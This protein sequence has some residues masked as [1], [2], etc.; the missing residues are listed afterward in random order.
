MKS[1]KISSKLILSYAIVLIFMVVLGVSS[2]VGISTLNEVI[3]QYKDNTVPT[4]NLVWQA[5]RDLISSQRNLLIAV[6]ATD[7]DLVQHYLNLAAKDRDNVFVSLD[8]LKEYE[9]VDDGKVDKAVSLIHQGAQY[10]EQI[11]SF[12]SQLTFE[13]NGQSFLVFTSNYQPIM[14][15][16]AQTLI[17]IAEDQ[18][19]K[20]LDLDNKSAKSVVTTYSVL[21][22]MFLLSIAAVFVIVFVLTKIIARPIRRLEKAA[23]SIAAGQF[24]V[25]LKVDGRDEIGLLTESFIKLRDTVLSLVSNLGKLNEEFDA[26]E[27][28]ATIPMDGFEGEFGVAVSSINKTV[29]S[30]VRD[31]LNILGAFNKFGEGDFSASIPQYPGKKALANQNFENLKNNFITISRDINKLIQAAIDGKLSARID[32]SVYSGDWKKMTQGLNDLCEAI[33]APINEANG[34]LEQLSNGNFDVSVNSRYS[35]D[36]ALM[37]NTLE[38]MISTT[39]GYIDEINK[40]LSLLADGDLRNNISREYVGQYDSIKQSINGISKDFKYTIS[41]IIVSAENVLIGAKQISETS[42]ELANGAS[43]QA[44]SVEELNASILTMNEQTQLNAKKSKDA[45]E[46]S[47]KSIESARV[48][49]EEMIKMLNSMNDIKEASRN[50]S[51]IMKTIDDI[52]FQTNILALNAAVEAARAGTHGRGFAVVAEEV[53]SL[54]GKS[55]EAASETAVLID[56]TISKINEGTQIAKVTA[57]S[58]RTIV[59][60]TNSVSSIINEIFE[61]TKN[62]AE[63]IA[64]I[65]LGI[66]QISEVVQTNS[67]T[68]EESAAAAEE[69]NSQSEMLAQMVS[70]FKV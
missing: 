42:M 51:K 46:F 3:N 35:G 49:N 67:S 22:S 18:N 61:A 14:D 30:L 17:S 10:R 29:G 55:K 34:I 69:L 50:I 59:S 36:F 4:Q 28:D 40:V 54:A 65:T 32:T 39:K 25:N 45:E 15:Q 1:L 33:I 27:I 21:I 16:V 13:G 48:G 70:K 8:K 44:S 20:I 23:S 11:E 38:R 63:G 43:A 9:N 53:R 19:A 58:L 6:S 60:D 5:R 47:R 24:N 57:D 26:G 41:E 56:D 52:A 37:M 62:Q 2:Y 12:A 66:N 31:T 7:K 64:Q 68:S